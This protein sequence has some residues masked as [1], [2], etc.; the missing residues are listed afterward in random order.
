MTDLT[1]SFS[2]HEQIPL[3]DYAEKAYLDY[4]MYHLDGSEEFR[5]LDALLGGH[6]AVEGRRDLERQI[7]DRGGALQ[8]CDVPLAQ[9]GVAADRDDHFG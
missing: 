4:S 9:L 2:D 8:P 6:R 7:V 5:H 1:L 3:K